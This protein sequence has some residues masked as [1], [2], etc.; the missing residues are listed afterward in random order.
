MPALPARQLRHVPI[1]PDDA[2]A[3]IRS[4]NRTALDPRPPNDTT[5]P[6]DPGPGTKARPSPAYPTRKSLRV[7]QLGLAPH[8]IRFV[9]FACA[10]LRSVGTPTPTTT[11]TDYCP[12]ASNFNPKSPTPEPICVKC[13]KDQA[14]STP[15]GVNRARI[16]RASP[17][18]QRRRQTA[19]TPKHPTYTKQQQEANITQNIPD[20]HDPKS[21]L[22]QTW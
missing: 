13:T 22:S 6:S 12:P 16:T 4:V 1:A 17:A 2:R 15:K 7:S 20:D 19:Y 5:N 11:V 14:Q 21:P 3:Q 9:A 18:V 10:S 8:L